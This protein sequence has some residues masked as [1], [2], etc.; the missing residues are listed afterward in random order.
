[1][2]L[3]NNL[4]LSCKHSEEEKEKLNSAKRKGEKTHQTNLL[5]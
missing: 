4:L 1:M 3:Q 2:K 5:P